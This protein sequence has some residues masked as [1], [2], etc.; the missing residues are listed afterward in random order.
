MASKLVLV[1]LF[2]AAVVAAASARPRFLAIPIE[3]IQF[4]RGP[5]PYP[6]FAPQQPALRVRRASPIDEERQGAAS[7]PRASSSYGGNDYVDYGAY[8]GGNGAFGWYS[9]HPVGNH[10]SGSY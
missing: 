3:D 4:L 8:T 7:Q 1:T 6:G 10:G 5:A 9:D 2:L